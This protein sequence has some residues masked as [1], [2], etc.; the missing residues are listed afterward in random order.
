VAKLRTMQKK[1][2]GANG[3]EAAKPPKV[4]EPVAPKPA[5]QRRTT[6]ERER[7]KDRLC[8]AIRDAREA[9]GLSQTELGQRL[10]PP[11]TQRSIAHIENGKFT[12]LGTGEWSRT[13][14]LGIGLIVELEQVLGLAPGHLMIV[15]GYIPNPE[16]STWLAIDGDPRLSTEA[17]N[18]LLAAYQHLAQ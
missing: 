17:K 2:N 15:A 7:A 8:K 16:P 4:V 11:I 13:V 6:P 18:A 3:D 1:A 12:T 14:G 10:D 5:P 9:A